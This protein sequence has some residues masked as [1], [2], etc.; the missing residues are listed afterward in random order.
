MNRLICLILCIVACHTSMYAQLQSPSKF[1]PYEHGSR[2]TPHHLLVDYVRHAAAQSPKIQVE[3]Y[4][5][6]H[7][8]RP[9][10]LAYISSEENLAQL[11]A[12]RDNNLRKTGL[13]DGE[14]DP[15][16]DR[17]IVWLSFGVHGN[18][19]GASES[20]PIVIYELLQS[21]NAQVQEWLKNTIV[22]IDPSLNPDGYS[23][24]THW[25]QG[26]ASKHPSATGNTREHREPWP[27][28][29]V[30]HYLFDL[31]RD[32]AWQT[33]IESQKRLTVYQQWMPHIHVDYHEQFPNNPYYFA[34]AAAP[35]HDYINDF[36]RSFQF[37]IGR[38]HARY[39][40]ENGWLYFTREVFDLL[41]PSYGDTYPLFH[42]AIGMTHE[43]AG[44]G[45]AGRAYTMENGDTL[46]LQDRID[47]HTATA[48][49]TLEVASTNADQLIEQFEKYF[50]IAQNDP[51]GKYKTFIVKADN[52][53][54]RIKALCDLLDKN[55]I[56]YKQVESPVSVNAYQYKNGETGS[57][58]VNEGDLLISAYQPM[59]VMVQVL[60]E[61]APSL[62]DTL[63]YDI[64]AW[65]L[66]Y[67]FGLEAYATTQ[68][69]N[70]DTDF[71]FSNY[72]ATTTKGTPYAFAAEWKSFANAK[73]LA[74]LQDA[75]IKVRQAKVP[76]S[77]GGQEYARGTLLITR[78]DNRKN[79]DWAKT[80][81]NIAFSLEQS[82]QP[83][84]TGFVDSGADL[85]SDMMSFLEKPKVAILSGQGI[86]PYSF[87]E[88]WHFFEQSLQYP[89]DIYDASQINQIELSN[90]NV[91]I[92][93]EGQYSWTEDTQKDIQDWLIK[94][95]RI[96]AIGRALHSLAQQDLFGIERKGNAAEEE[97]EEIGP[98]YHHH[99]SYSGQSRRGLSNSIP[100]AIFSVLLDRTHPLAFGLGEQY[101]T[102]KTSAAAY[103]FL[104]QGW[105]VGYIN[106]DREHIGF[107]GA[108]ALKQVERSLAIGMEQKGQ[109]TIIYLVD[110]PLFRAF[111]EQGKLLM[112]NAI[113]IN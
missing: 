55:H 73:F 100:G 49:S 98:E 57:V 22:I 104:D 82:I 24:Y 80:V 27:G 102:L 18:E 81:N 110:D 37:D 99:H 87:G 42:G 68:R 11:D 67:A 10:M 113:F 95:G 94:G 83:L 30:N 12:I 93:P 17:A 76:F 74:S 91:L 29:R 71:T 106:S 109:G 53:E 23:R 101:Y 31:N 33:Q 35:Y 69:I 41:Y 64:T 44:H 20:A 40:D 16:L 72:E 62:E 5:Y 45:L 15:S 60:F 9:L 21:D 103:Q 111:W 26:I 8:Q 7:E 19:A 1:F 38:N 36:Q 63:T 105:N 14:S 75:G 52:P 85:G 32:W 50:E 89:A 90:Y 84:N 61:P 56:Y 92:L 34:P 43:Q 47:H 54:K 78:A 107:A 108:N 13:L 65:A 25:Y 77:V 88:L 66:P 3:Q 112:S 48:L 39:F 6:T 70:S 86:S 58:Q 2:F 59:S 51:L 79:D 4:G 46:T 96:I 28:G 97:E